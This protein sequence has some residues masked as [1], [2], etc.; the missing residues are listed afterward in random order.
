MFDFLERLRE[1]PE[2]ARRRIVF[3]GAFGVTAVISLVWLSTLGARLD[4]ASDEPG[5]RAA[6]EESASS[7]SF[8]REQTAAVFSVFQDTR[9]SIEGIADQFDFDTEREVFIPREDLDLPADA[10]DD[11]PDEA[12]EPSSKKREVKLLEI[13]PSSESDLEV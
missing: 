3:A 6:V 9:E 1:K 13:E 7:F 12:K 11:Q 4:R 10:R 8:L 5:R 2:G